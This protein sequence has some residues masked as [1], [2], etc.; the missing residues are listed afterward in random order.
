MFRCLGRECGKRGP[1]IQAL[2]S[3]DII[4]ERNDGGIDL[5]IVDSDPS[6]DSPETRRLLREKIAGNLRA[7][8]SD[9][10]QEE[11]GFQSAEQTRIVVACLT[12][13]NPR[14]AGLDQ[15]LPW[16]IQWHNDLVPE[17]DLRMG[18]DYYRDFVADEAQ[19]L[20]YTL[21]QVRVWASPVKVK[22]RRGKRAG[23]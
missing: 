10:F 4:G 5:A 11:Y 9:A 14:L 7:I 3:I 6:D 2:D 12:E 1:A 20:G 17:Y 8:N 21:D 16:L 18:D 19:T 13:P 22:G 23:S 15:L